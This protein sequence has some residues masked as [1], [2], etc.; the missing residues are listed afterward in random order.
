MASFGTHPQ[1]LAHALQVKVGMDFL[2]LFVMEDE[3]GILI[4]MLAAALME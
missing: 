1:M 3:F 2:V 4:Q